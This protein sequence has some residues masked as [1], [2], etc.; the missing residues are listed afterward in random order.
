[1]EPRKKKTSKRAAGGKA[2]GIR[3]GFP[4]TVASGISPSVADVIFTSIESSG[5]YGN[6]TSY[7]LA[8]TGFPLPELDPGS[9]ER[10]GPGVSLYSFPDDRALVLVIPDVST[11]TGGSL[12]NQLHRSLDSLRDR[13]R[14][15]TLWIPLLAQWG[16]EGLTP[17]DSLY[18][19][20]EA[21][22][23]VLEKPG[24][25]PFEPRHVIISLWEGL[26]NRVK[27]EL[28][29]QAEEHLGAPIFRSNREALF[30][31]AVETDVLELCYLLALDRKLSPERLLEPALDS[32]AEGLWRLGPKVGTPPEVG[33]ALELLV[34]RHGSVGPGPLWTAWMRRTLSDRLTALEGELRGRVS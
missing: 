1:M 34:E 6:L 2:G 28:Q 32:I 19:T 10:I 23:D 8:E 27:A 21:I 20:V 30:V 9:A 11:R 26:P 16:A 17:E 13:C 29:D 24:S 18:V 4:I 7:V 15:R 3:P 22:D 31:P 12:F 14:G 5:R 25:K 33:K